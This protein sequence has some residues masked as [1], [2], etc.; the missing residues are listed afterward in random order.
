MGA[1]WVTWPLEDEDKTLVIKSLDFKDKRC[2]RD[3][4]YTDLLRA[5]TV[6]TAETQ[7]AGA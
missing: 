7:S 3:T 6:Y 1:S 5:S 2:R 4:V